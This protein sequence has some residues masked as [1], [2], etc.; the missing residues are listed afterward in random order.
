MCFIKLFNMASKSIYDRWI[1]IHQTCFPYIVFKKYATELK[2]LDMSYESSKRFTYERLKKEGAVWTDKAS[3]FLFTHN[4]DEISLKTWADTYDDFDNWL[5]LNKLLAMS[6]YF[7]TYIAAIISLAL[8]SDPGILIGCPH[9]VDGIKLKKLGISPIS[10]EDLKEHL[11]Q[12]TRGDWMAR[13]SHMK[14]LFGVIPQSLTDKLSDLEKMRNLPNS[15]IIRNETKLLM[16]ENGYHK[17]NY[18]TFYNKDLKNIDFSR[19]HFG[20]LT[21]IEVEP[22]QT[23]R[24][25]RNEIFR[26]TLTQGNKIIKESKV[27]PQIIKNLTL[28]TAGTRIIIL[29]P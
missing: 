25:K 6:S 3:K 22:Y 12:C 27:I 28:I 24:E 26:N 19:D 9:C 8:E 29:P 16:E 17:K 15:K 13:T 20:K 11:K 18:F 1:P 10:E 4:N 14:K 21:W 2:R 23:L 5:R 7:E